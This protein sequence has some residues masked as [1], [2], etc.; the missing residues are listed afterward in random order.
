MKFTL[1]GH[2]REGKPL[3][4]VVV[5]AGSAQELQHA[6]EGKALKFFELKIQ[7]TDPQDLAELVEILPSLK[8]CI[9]AKPVLSHPE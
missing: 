4:T 8:E 6:I 5:D 7:V 9:T 1:I 2:L 3:H